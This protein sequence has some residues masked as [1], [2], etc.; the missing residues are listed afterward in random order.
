MK[1]E[2]LSGEGVP[3]E[4]LWHSAEEVPPVEVGDLTKFWVAVLSHYK[5]KDGKPSILVFCAS[6]ANRPLFLN[7]GGEPTTDDYHTNE[8]GE[9]VEVVGWMNEFHHPD[10]DGYYETINFNDEYQLLGWAEYTVPVWNS[11]V[12]E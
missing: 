1:S 2:V 9:P 12:A 8:D 3:P 5:L 7:E 4:V 11:V 6:Y 10:F